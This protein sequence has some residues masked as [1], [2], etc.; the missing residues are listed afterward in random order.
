[1]KTFEEALAGVMVTGDMTNLETQLEAA[2][3][4]E[5]AR[6]RYRELID[7]AASNPAVRRA[8]EGMLAGV[9]MGAMPASSAMISMFVN[10]LVC[11]IEME[12]GEL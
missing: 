4:I 6:S 9:V 1:M 11:G 7:Q 8:I 10:G 2:V 12:K 5:N 3:T